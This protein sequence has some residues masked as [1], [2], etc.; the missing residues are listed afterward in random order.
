MPTHLLEGMTQITP[1][2]TTPIAFQE[3]LRCQPHLIES[4]VQSTPTSRTSETR[5]H[6][7]AMLGCVGKM[8]PREEPRVS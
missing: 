7:P 8:R 2:T 5:R 6:P 4:H 3:T 1:T